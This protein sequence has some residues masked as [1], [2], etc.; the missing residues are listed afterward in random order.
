MNDVAV[1][2]DRALNHGR[3]QADPA[4][5]LAQ[6]QT[7]THQA[8]ATSTPRQDH[9][10]KISP[11]EQRRTS[12]LLERRKKPCNSSVQE[13]VLALMAE[14][15]LLCQTD[16][17][18]S[19]RGLLVPH[20]GLCATTCAANALQA[21]FAH[22]G[23]DISS[24]RASDE[25]VEALVDRIAELEQKDARLGIDFDSLART[26]ND[27]ANALHPG[28]GVEAKAGRAAIRYGQDLKRLVHTADTLVV[29]G[30][31]TGSKTGH[32]VLLL[33]VNPRE[34][35]VTLSDPNDPNQTHTAGYYFDQHGDLA[36]RDFGDYGAGATWPGYGRVLSRL[37]VRVRRRRPTAFLS[38][39]VL[40]DAASA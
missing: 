15:R 34:H 10:G 2:H 17:R 22:Q 9:Y 29:L 18:L 37:E 30:V 39:A 24:K 40:S 19:R 7:P 6:T 16:R 26:L 25:L 35:Q 27:V 3:A 12:L 33:S 23:R 4:T 38:G 14:R 32:A 21:A 1:Y 11:Q 36:L 8:K 28:V 31:L 20:G 5:P 13:I